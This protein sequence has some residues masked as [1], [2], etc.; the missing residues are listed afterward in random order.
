MTRCVRQN[1]E[2]ARKNTAPGVRFRLQLDRP[3]CSHRWP[4]AQGRRG[5]ERRPRTAA[6]VRP[7][8]AQ[9]RLCRAPRP[10]GR[11]R[12]SLLPAGA[13]RTAVDPCARRRVFCWPSPDPRACPPDGP[14]VP[15]PPLRLLW[16]RH[17]QVCF[18][19]REGRARRI[20]QVQ[21]LYLSSTS[22]EFVHACPSF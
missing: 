4:P 21:K 22:R 16:L 5:R 13:A 8:P 11:G 9:G 7:P 17:P 3:V 19:V 12:A 10:Q 6:P 20:S 1:Y 2:Q 15:G 18:A 14:R